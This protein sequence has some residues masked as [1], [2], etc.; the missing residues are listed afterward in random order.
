MIDSLQLKRPANRLIGLSATPGRTW[1]NIEADAELANFFGGEKLTIE[2]PGY[3]DPVQFLVDH[4]YLARTHFRRLISAATD[5]RAE[6]DSAGD[7]IS[8]ASLLEL[9]ENQDRNVQIVRVV[10]ELF[11]RHSRII[12]FAASVPHAKLISM[13]LSLRGLDSSVVTA[14]TDP[15]TREALIRRF[16]L[17]DGSKRIICNYGVLTTGFDAPKTSA[18]VIARPTRSLVLFSQMVG[19]AIRGPRAGGNANCEIVTIVDPS[20]PGFGSVADAFNN[21]EDVWA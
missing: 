17:E 7:D 2:V 6:L 5:F 19:R 16:K 3:S 21:W 4:G 1:N 18:A 11:E 13:I 14:E 8:Q 15:V 12:L 20:L 10:E 9:G